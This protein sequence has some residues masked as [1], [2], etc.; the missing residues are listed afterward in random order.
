VIV[1]QT[2]KKERVQKLTQASTFEKFNDKILKN[3]QELL[4]TLK[5]LKNKNKKIAGYGASGRGTIIT[6]YCGLD[7]ELLDYVIDDAPANKEHICQAYTYQLNHPV[8]YLVKTDR[9]IFY[10]LLGLLQMRF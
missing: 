1:S 3:K 10:F 4:K 7:N 2:L 6:N 8:N 9:T 5:L